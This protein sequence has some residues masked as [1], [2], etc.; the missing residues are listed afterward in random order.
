ML[1]KI[2]ILKI[3]KFQEKIILEVIFT[4]KLISKILFNFRKVWKKSSKI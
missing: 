2:K 3:T 1:L 4:N